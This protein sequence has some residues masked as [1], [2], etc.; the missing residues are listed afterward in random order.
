MRWTGRTS[1]RGR[2][3]S[4][5]DSDRGDNVDTDIKEQEVEDKEPLDRFMIVMDTT[6]KG[7]QTNDKKGTAWG[8][9][10]GGKGRRDIGIHRRKKGA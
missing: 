10:D 4:T 9:K 3:G 8:G 2:A 7:S 6:R 5:N 1:S